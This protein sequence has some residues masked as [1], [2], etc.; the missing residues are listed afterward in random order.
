MS[1]RENTPIRD[2]L[3]E[4]HLLDTPTLA[5]QAPGKLLQ[6]AAEKKREELTS[7]ATALDVKDVQIAL[8]ELDIAK[9]D[10]KVN[11]FMKQIALVDC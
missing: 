1:S 5:R 9:N 10:K 3:A 6:T 4:A 8:F 7:L 2:S 11:A